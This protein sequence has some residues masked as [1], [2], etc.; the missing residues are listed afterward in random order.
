MDKTAGIRDL[1]NNLSRYLRRLA[2]GQVLAITD[3]GR[4]VAEL[5]AH[6]GEWESGPMIAD[7]Y[8][9]LVRSGVIRRAT[10]TGDPLIHW[11]STRELKLPPGTAASLVDE[12]RGG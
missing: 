8:A 2:P 10:E 12:D 3:R 1:K 5:R 11:P 9:R 4:I 7:G 6:G